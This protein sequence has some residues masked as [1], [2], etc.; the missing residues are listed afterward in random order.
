MK[1]ILLLTSCLL[2]A[3]VIA[4]QK[5]T[6]LF[7]LADCR[8]TIDTMYQ[9][10]CTFY[11]LRYNEDDLRRE[12]TRGWQNAHCA[13]L[14]QNL[15]RQ[16][17]AMQYFDVRHS[18]IANV[19]AGWQIYT[20]LQS[21]CRECYN[22]AYATELAYY[23]SRQPLAGMPY[24]EQEA[25]YEFQNKL[26][27][28][29][30]STAITDFDRYLAKQ[31][32]SAPGRYELPAGRALLKIQKIETIYNEKKRASELR[33]LDSLQTI[34]QKEEQK[35]TKKRNANS[36][37]KWHSSLGKKYGPATANR[38][39]NGEMWLGM[40]DNMI[41]DTYGKPLRTLKKVN[42]KGTTETW[43]YKCLPGKNETQVVDLTIT[44]KN[45][46]VTEWKQKN[47]NLN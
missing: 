17:K 9:R 20:D 47:T 35:R 40:S 32:G 44:F 30:N 8:F 12:S 13:S 4:R 21:H 6:P 18:G 29:E 37:R 41:A 5:N 10:G 16:L 19:K 3:M 34:K 45:H 14:I 25:I 42:K 27:N 43:Y 23:S 39:T 28:A 26:L 2:S 38:L 1:N 36:I 7:T 31:V 46:L 22:E 24:K 33:V 15:Q 11:C